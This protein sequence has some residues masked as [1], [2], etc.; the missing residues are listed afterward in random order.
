MSN[1][2]D[3]LESDYYDENNLKEA[4]EHETYKNGES[5][6]KVKQIQQTQQ[7]NNSI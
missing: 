3:M 6:A 7:Y 4:N 2:K 1:K 5:C